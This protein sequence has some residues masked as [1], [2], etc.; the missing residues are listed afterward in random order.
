MFFVMSDLQTLNTMYHFSSA[1]FLALFS[2]VPPP[3]T[4]LSQ[5]PLFSQCTSCNQVIAGC[6]MRNTLVK[7]ACWHMATVQS[8]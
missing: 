2:K 8:V 1:E 3:N 5:S 7:S 4:V 6:R